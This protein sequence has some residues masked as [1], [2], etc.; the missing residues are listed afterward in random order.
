MTNRPAINE[1]EVTAR[2]RLLEVVQAMLD[3]NM[4]FF[5]G[6]R[7]VF[8]LRHQVG[9]VLVSD[10]DFDAFAVIYSET[11][12]LPHEDQRYLWSSDTL[13][14][15]EPEFKHTEEWAESFAL[16]ACKNLIARF[17]AE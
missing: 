12:H 3:R 7:E 4:S 16:P 8:I 5:H 10:P 1:F 15:L 6:A 9:G 14:K 11:D 2:E 17:E 13:E